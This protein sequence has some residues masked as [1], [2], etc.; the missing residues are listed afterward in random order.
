MDEPQKGFPDGTNNWISLP[1]IG[2]RVAQTFCIDRSILSM[3]YYH[4]YKYIPIRLEI[5][6]EEY[7][8]A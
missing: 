8:C 1:C 3:S 7:F 2:G 4:I 5:E 6:I